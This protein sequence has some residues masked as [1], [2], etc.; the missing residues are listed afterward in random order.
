MDDSLYEDLPLARR[1]VIPG[2]GFF[3]DGSGPDPT[4]DLAGADAVV[5]ADGDADGLGCAALIREAHDDPLPETL[6]YESFEP[7]AGGDVLVPAAPHSLAAALA[8]V[9]A[10]A[11]PEAP[12]YVCDLC[13]DDARDL[14]ALPALVGD[15]YDAV[16]AE[17]DAVD[18]LE[19]DVDP[20]ALPDPRTGA[21]PGSV[22]RRV[23][24]F[25]HHQWEPALAEQVRAAGVD[26]VIGASDEVCSTDVARRSLE[27][28]LDGGEELAR[29]T[30][31]HDLWIREDPRS[32]DLA[33][34][35]HWSPAELYVATVRTHGPDLPEPARA[36]LA[37]RRREK[38]ALVRKAA[39]RAELRDVAGVTVG[40]T[41]GRCSQ[42]EVAQALRERGAN[43]AAV[44]KPSG[45]ASLRGTDAFARCHEVARRLGGGGHPKAAGCKPDVYDDV[46]DYAHHWTTRGAT[47]RRVILEAFE[48]VVDGADGAVS[49]AA[50]ETASVEGDG[51][52]EDAPDR[53][54]TDGNAAG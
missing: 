33:D 8:A 37:Q 5:I 43:A 27:L 36:F 32:Q 29:V 52:L 49:A 25:D 40:I 11:P 23:R 10:G 51:S 6:D 31:D 41:Y 13:P 16:D 22:D 21:A 48:A 3:G 54:P 7:P 53:E 28:E 15:G 39:E 9:A 34:Y 35:A 42:N 38:D 24:W 18:E 14:A 20:D 47:A 12:V 26:L 45:S 4:D 50:V 46:L 2:E 44:V 17:P 1:S 30:R 19:A